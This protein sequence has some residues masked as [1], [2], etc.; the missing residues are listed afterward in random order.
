[1][2]SEFNPLGPLVV[3]TT[4]L[5]ASVLREEAVSATSVELGGKGWEIMLSVEVFLTLPWIST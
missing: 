2:L 4:Q 5:V 3:F 1:M